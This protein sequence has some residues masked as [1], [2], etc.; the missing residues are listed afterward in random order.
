MWRPGGVGTSRRIESAV[1]LLPQ[2]DSPTTPS[3]RPA[4]TVY[5]T[6]STER[7]VPASVLK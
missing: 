5:D 2:P 3:V 6:P 4:R 7:T 1:T